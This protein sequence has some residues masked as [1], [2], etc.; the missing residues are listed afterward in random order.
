MFVYVVSLE[1]AYEGDVLMGVFSDYVKA[2]EF[3]LSK[4]ENGSFLSQDVVIRK[5][6]IDKIYSSAFDGIGE[7]M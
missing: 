1:I 6:E 3:M 5:V 2:R 7:E 4:C